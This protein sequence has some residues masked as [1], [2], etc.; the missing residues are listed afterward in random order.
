M[1]GINLEEAIKKLKDH[2]KRHSKTEYIPLEK[3]NGRILGRDYVAPISNPPFDRSPLDGYAFKASSSRGAT[4]ESPVVLKVIGEVCAGGWFEGSIEA[5]EAV[6]IMTGAPIPKGCDCVLR[7]EDTDEG[8]ENVSIYKELT[9]YSN[10]C[11]EGEDIK[12]GTPLFKE[13]ERLSP[14]T[15]GVLASMGIKEVEVRQK[16]KVGLL[17]TGDELA[18]LGTPLTKG[19]IYNTNEVMLRTKMEALGVEVL[20]LQMINDAP[21]EVA[22]LLMKHWDEIDLM[23]TTGGVS[24]GKKDIM[25]EV[26]ELIEASRLFWRIAIQPGTPVLAATYKEKLMVGLSGNPFA[27]LVNFEVIIRPLLA[28]MIG[29]EKVA[30]ICTRAIMA[31]PF[32]KKSIKRRFIRVAYKEGFVWINHTNHASG[33]LYTMSLCNALVD[34]PAGTEYIREGEEVKVLLLDERRY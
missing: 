34:I 28:H 27:A 16:I 22:K 12:V 24:V 31:T 18:P 5:G 1:V 29:D 10:Y 30:P 23:V 7:K 15:L 26:I 2:A 4:K 3:A 17:C 8:E 11:F 13:G 6:H 33:A 32:D 21:E 25:H 9:P 14:I 20:V 19:K